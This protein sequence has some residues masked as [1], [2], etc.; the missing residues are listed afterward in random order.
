MTMTAVSQCAQCGAVINIHWSSC[1]VCRAVIS[2]DPVASRPRQ[3]AAGHYEQL[4]ES[5]VLN[6]LGGTTRAATQDPL[7]IDPSTSPLPPY[8][9]V[10]Y[11]DTQGRL[12]GGWDERATCTVK[13]SHGVGANCQVE[14]ANGVR[15][16]LRA[17]RAVGH[18]NAA[19]RLVG[20]WT[21]REHGYDGNGSPKPGGV[22]Q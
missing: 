15:I 10:T 9:F 18:L 19:G 1:L 6:E 22:F 3:I 11:I 5:V 14:L 4:E 8:C 2:S 20:A 16:P 21:V 7:P 17:V 13:Q 12:R